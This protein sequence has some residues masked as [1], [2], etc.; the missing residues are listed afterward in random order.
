MPDRWCRSCAPS[1]ILFGVYLSYSG[2]LTVMTY[3]W[4]RREKNRTCCKWHLRGFCTISFCH[5]CVR[6]IW[7]TRKAVDI[8]IINR[9]RWIWISSCVGFY[10]GQMLTETVTYSCSVLSASPLICIVVW[11][12]TLKSA[13]L[14][15]LQWKWRGTEK[16]GLDWVLRLSSI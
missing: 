15:D 1:L 3:E 13:L 6:P 10:H 11:P 14:R 4:P 2:L 16:L 5:I 8:G 12:P 7:S 9:S